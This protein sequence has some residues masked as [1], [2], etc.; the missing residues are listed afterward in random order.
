[1]CSEL[2]SIFY[3]QCT[4]QRGDQ[5]LKHPLGRQLLHTRQESEVLVESVTACSIR[6]FQRQG[7]TLSSRSTLEANCWHSMSCTIGS[8]QRLPSMHSP[9]C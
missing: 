5:H 3:V 8:H 4:A 2:L 7:A 9:T 6:T 1:V